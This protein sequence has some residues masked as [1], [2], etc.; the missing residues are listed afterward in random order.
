MRK[1]SALK[2]GKELWDWLGI[3][4]QLA[5]F[6]GL[7]GLIVS[8]GGTVWATIIG[9]PPPFILMAGFCTLVATVWIGLAP[10]AYESFTKPA[11]GPA[12]K[13]ATQKPNYSAWRNRQT[14]RICEAACLFADLVPSSKNEGRADV[15]EYLGALI[16]AATSRDMEFVFRYPEAARSYSKHDLEL[17][18]VD[19]NTRVTLDA[20]RK[21]AQKRGYNPPFLRDG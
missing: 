10:I 3:A 21:F 5:G 9:L 14:V 7:A 13:A 4:W 8:I 16:D 1:W 17:Q 11:I 12:E 18:Y 2:R 20:L 15:L 19:M 6:F